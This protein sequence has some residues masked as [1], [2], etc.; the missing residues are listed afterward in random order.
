[1]ARQVTI[2][3]TFF[4]DNSNFIYDINFYFGQERTRMLSVFMKRV[5]DGEFQQRLLLEN[6]SSVSLYPS[7]CLNIN[8]HGSEH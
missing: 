7:S 4:S 3:Y 5:F 2:H 6:D 8:I 1:M